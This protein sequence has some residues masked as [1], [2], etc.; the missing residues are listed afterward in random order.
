MAAMCL[1]SPFWTEF[2][3]TNKKENKVILKFKKVSPKIGE[4]F[5]MARVRCV[6][7]ATSY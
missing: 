3:G 7:Y 1:T 5:F 4:T 6:K 2:G